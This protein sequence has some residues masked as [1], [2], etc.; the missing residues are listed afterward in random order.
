MFGIHILLMVDIVDGIESAGQ[1]NDV[2]TQSPSTIHDKWY[3]GKELSVGRGK[4]TEIQIP[5]ETSTA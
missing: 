2:C 5:I 4:R 3:F 1:M